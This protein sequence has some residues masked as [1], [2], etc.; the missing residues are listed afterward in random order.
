MLNKQMA[1]LG[2]VLLAAVAVALLILVPG[3]PGA[4]DRA[5]ATTLRIWVDKDPKPAV[6]KVAGQW[7]ASR[8]VT[9][10][11]V[12]KGFGNIRS[13]LGTVDAS[14]AP[15]VIFSASDWTGELAANGLVVPLFPKKSV[16]KVFP[17]YALA[18]YTY[19]QLYGAPTAIENLGLVVNTRLA[20][21]PKTFAQLE[22]EAIAFKKKSGD[23]IAIA[24]PQ[25]TA[26]D[27]YH[28]YPFFSGLCGYVF[29]T[30]K[31][32]AL[33]PTKLGVANKTFLKNA[34]LIDKWNREG[35]INS[36]VGYND[37][38]DAFLKGRAAF[39]ITGPWESDTLKSSGLKFRIVQVPKIKC[40]SVPFLGV[41]GFMVT[42]YSATHGVQSLAKDLVGRY[43][44]GVASQVE[45]AAANGR[46][47]AN[48][49]AGKRVNDAV[50]KQFGKAGVGGVP[51]PN[52]PQMA[53]VWTELAGA[54]VKATKGAG[55][56]SAR[57][58]F[59]AAAKSI[60]KKIASG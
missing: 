23:N 6:E 34:P 26:G 54:W 32:G 42:K 49:N 9:L 27:A 36:K 33:S 8:G 5:S 45:L 21:V 28:M 13:D 50:L 10:Q 48:V 20:K 7:A 31:S 25:G 55:A 43:M 53:S 12:E 59:L 18:A 35:L 17:K 11:V 58:A 41:R 56:T 14:Q 4:R 19:K 29:G 24:V 2:T 37:A 38:K 46:F 60:A 16:T 40:R 39:W 15:D 47:P 51:L 57:S 22:K 44:M 1:R 3:A 30:T 52:I